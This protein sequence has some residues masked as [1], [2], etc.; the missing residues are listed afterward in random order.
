MDLFPFRLIVRTNQTAIKFTSFVLVPS[1]NIEVKSTCAFIIIV[2]MNRHGKKNCLITLWKSPLYDGFHSWEICTSYIWNE[3]VMIILFYDYSY[4]EVY[5]SIYRIWESGFCNLHFRK[6]LNWNKGHFRYSF[7]VC[8]GSRL[9]GT[10]NLDHF[11][12]KKLRKVDN[13]SLFWKIQLVTESR[14]TWSIAY[15]IIWPTESS[16]WSILISPALHRPQILP[17]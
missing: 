16:K 13:L 8:F 14:V 11:T 1:I 9:I 7:A 4:L 17:R 6:G 10:L 3:L 5:S 15:D 12:D 2:H